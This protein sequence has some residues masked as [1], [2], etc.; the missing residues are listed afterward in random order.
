MTLHASQAGF[1]IQPAIL[2]IINYFINQ[3]NQ[4]LE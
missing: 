1:Y 4:Q 2:N 3:A